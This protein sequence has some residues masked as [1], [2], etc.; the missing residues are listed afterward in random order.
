MR[1]VNFIDNQ[2]LICNNV[3]LNIT[4]NITMEYIL[5]VTQ[6]ITIFM[7]IKFNKKVKILNHENNYLECKN[8]SV[9]VL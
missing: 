2:F 6:L 9:I 3:F 8:K 5:L 1:I 4:K 7:L